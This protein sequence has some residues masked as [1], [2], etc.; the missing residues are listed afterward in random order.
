RWG[1]TDGLLHGRPVQLGL[2]ALGVAAAL[3]YSGAVTFALLKLIDVVL[4]LRAAARAEGVGMDISQ[5][6]EEAYSDGEGA[7]L[8]FRD[9]LT[10]RP[11]LAPVATA[12]AA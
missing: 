2:Q 7:V 12:G 3:A 11:A 10:P 9:T 4:P 8:V 6:G 1:G 5:H